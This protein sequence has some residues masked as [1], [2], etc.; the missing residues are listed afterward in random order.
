MPS[1]SQHY[2][3]YR[4]INTIHHTQSYSNYQH[5]N[6]SHKAPPS[7]IMCFVNQS[8]CLGCTTITETPAPKQPCARTPDVL[9]HSCQGEK[10]VVAVEHTGPEFCLNCYH[11]ELLEIRKKW[12]QREE[13][14]TRKAKKH[15]Y[16]PSQADSLSASVKQELSK[17]IMRLDQMWEKMWCA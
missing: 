13:A 12:E 2:S 3:I 7:I 16:K 5:Q 15:G 1:G 14:C 6:L 4:H 9:Q 10:V 8:I 11:N 17:D